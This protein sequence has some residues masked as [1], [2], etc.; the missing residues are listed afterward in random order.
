ML[1]SPLVVL[2]IS[3]SS[4]L[5]HQVF[6]FFSTAHGKIGCTSS[7]SAM[8]TDALQDIIERLNCIEKKIDILT[9]TNSDSNAEDENG[10]PYTSSIIKMSSSEPHI[11]I[12]T[13]AIRCLTDLGFPVS[14][15]N[16]VSWFCS[17]IKLN[18]LKREIERLSLDTYAVRMLIRVVYKNRKFELSKLHIVQ[19]IRAN[20]MGIKLC[21]IKYFWKVFKFEVFPCGLRFLDSGLS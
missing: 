12:K 6:L 18:S 10:K 21:V 7:T 11:R 9:N 1:T 20:I 3:I 5:L 14:T 15:N 16:S 2:L 19:F 13:S 4:P 17:S 8:N